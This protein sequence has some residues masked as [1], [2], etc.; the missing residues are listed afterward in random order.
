[1]SH[2]FPYSIKR[3]GT[4]LEKCEDEPV[5]TPGCIQAHGALLVLRRSDL[6][7][8]QASENSRDWLGLSPENL[9]GQPVSIAIGASS[10][11]LVR[12]ALGH[13]RMEKAPLFLM[14]LKPGE[15]G[16]RRALDVSLHTC[17]D[18]VLLEL[19]APEA[20]APEPPDPLYADPD[21]YG[22][23]RKTLTRFQEASSI[24]TLAQAVTEELRRITELDRVMV[25]Y[26]HADYS[27]EV[28][29]ESK[30]AGESSWLGWRFPAHDIPR[31]AREIFKRLWSRSVPDVRAELFEMVPLLNPD[32]RQP[33]DMTYCALRGASAMYTEYLANMGVRAAFTLPL[34]REGELWGLIACHHHS[35]KLISYRIR[36]AS[37]FL[38]R[39]ASQ[40][41][42]RAEESE[43]TKYRICLDEANYALVSK[44]A[45]APD[46]S[47]FTEGPIHLGSELDCGGAAIFC[48]E[49]WHKVGATPAIPEMADLGQWLRTQP[50]FRAGDPN[51]IFVTDHLSAQY[52]AG[53]AIARSA[54]GLMSFCFSQNPLGFVL[55]FKPETLQ[56]FTWAGNPNE[57]P[58][59]AG[60]RL[61]PRK[62][63]ELWRE[64]V[65]ERSLPWKKVEIDAALKL[66]DLMV[67][68]LVSKAEQLHTLRRQVAERTLE[69]EK[70]GEKIK[71]IAQRLSLATKALKA[72]IWDRDVR[73]NLVV[74]DE[75][76]Y[77][78]YGKPNNAPVSYETWASAVFP[79]DL[80]Q[81]EAALRSVIDSKSQASSDF[82]ILRPD[83]SIRYIHSALGAVLGATGEVER[84]VGV[85]LD[86]TE[87]KEL[88]LQFLRTQRMESIGTLAGGMAHNLNNLL[89]PILLSIELL[90]S[91][92]TDA[93]SEGI[94]DLIESSAKRGEAVVRQ[95]LAFARG[96]RI[97]K[98]EI[99]LGQLLHEV[100]SLIASTFPKNIRLRFYVPQDTWTILGD[101]AQIQQ[102]LLNLCLNARDAMPDG[103]SLEVK[104]D[105]CV[106]E[107]QM[108]PMNLRAKAGHYVTISVIDTGIGIPTNLQERIF[109]PF[110][111]TKTPQ[112]GT[113][114]GLSTTLAIVRSH[115][116][117][118][119]VD[120][121]PNQGATFKVSL[122]ATVAPSTPLKDSSG[123]ASLPEGIG[124]TVLVVDDEVPILKVTRMLLQAK[125]YR[126]LTAANGAEAL[127]AYTEHQ[128]EI[129]VVLIDMNMPVMDGPTA[130]RELLRINPAVQIIA[131]SGLG[132]KES[133]T[134]VSEAGVKHFL[135]KPYTTG[136]LLKAIR[137]VA[138]SHE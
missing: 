125:G 130:I 97:E 112:Q 89:T 103:G 70:S 110:F 17:S 65:S 91:M 66:R 138:G 57:L 120:S 53:K 102:I 131:V 113:G 101:P 83:G 14:T 128:D 19:E 22:L 54:S 74:W 43:N 13:E 127:A 41:L 105:N 46:L 8:L 59:A 123:A 72:G 87:R 4:T 56:T 93:R 77:E 60:A 9:L 114:L 40:Q 80:P 90:K 29:A 24:S 1:M 30:Q 96:D 111:T 31:P 79:E 88:E 63:F 38:A 42:W 95:V 85:N 78:I 76:L 26:F 33:L 71:L 100:E 11:Q 47:A 35:P 51:P 55:Y 115:D 12:S 58:G 36:A 108:G 126:V 137:A 99:Q 21:Y 84:V 64:T 122:P 27:G 106:L 45:L 86:V 39:G 117:I 49:S 25:Y 3:H 82:R 107:D 119:Q 34:R 10:A 129:A 6:T 94:L 75:K 136:T 37:E 15:Q 5:Q 98:A 133:V 81:V 52:P 73:T 23:V 109:E 7:I 48:Q 2:E 134:E 61:T 44:V 135:T 92:A 28:I 68:L 32:T 18:L 121:R 118:I 20:G 124:E 50:A 116:G 62:S 16:N 104:A 67:S 69:L 132:A